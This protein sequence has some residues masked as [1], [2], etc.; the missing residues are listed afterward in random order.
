MNFLCSKLNLAAI[1]NSNVL[2]MAARIILPM[3]H[4]DV[5][6]P[7]SH[8][9]RCCGEGRL[10]ASHKPGYFNFKMNFH[11]EVLVR[12]SY[13]KSSA[14]RASNSLLRTFTLLSARSKDSWVSAL[15]TQWPLPA[16]GGEL[17]L[18]CVREEGKISFSSSSESCHKILSLTCYFLH[19]QEIWKWPHLIEDTMYL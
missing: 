1:I 4:I 11:K 17:V 13:L 5:L 12:L 19:F 18:W 6:R 9:D 16:T 3:G 10:G 2:N 7:R 15:I 14:L 8:G